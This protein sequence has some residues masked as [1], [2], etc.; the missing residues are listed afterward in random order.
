MQAKIIYIAGKIS[1]L[2]KEDVIIKFATAQKEIHAKGHYVINPVNSV[3]GW[4]FTWQMCMKL[5]L[6]NLC[7]ANAIYLLPDWRESEGALIEY[8][9]ATSLGYDIYFDIN[10][11]PHSNNDINV[12]Y[13]FLDF[14]KVEN[15]I[16]VSTLMDIGRIQDIFTHL[17]KIHSDFAR[18]IHGTSYHLKNF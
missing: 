1:G 16:R 3:D 15:Q 2:K 18:V 9:L 6:K 17:G 12:N 14:M 8:K 7:N 13:E 11:I 4:D 10:D 5:A